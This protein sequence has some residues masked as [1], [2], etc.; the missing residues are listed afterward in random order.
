MIKDVL[1]R[2]KSP[3]VLGNI[4]AL[5]LFIMKNYGLLSPIGLTED[6]YNELTGIIMTILIGFGVLNNPTNE[7][8]F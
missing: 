8:D 1:S 6:S 3:I 2:L 7:N 4:M 5:I